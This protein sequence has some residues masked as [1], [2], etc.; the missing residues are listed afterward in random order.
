MMNH[1]LPLSLSLPL[2]G[3]N[4]RNLANLFWPSRDSHKKIWKHFFYKF[5]TKKKLTTR[6]STTIP[7]K[8]RVCDMTFD[9]HCFSFQS[10]SLFFSLS[11]TSPTFS[12]KIF[13]FIFRL[14]R[15]SVSSTNIHRDTKQSSVNVE[16]D[17]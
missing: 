3:P 9:G 2:F 1:I 5:C 17:F 10:L 13:L 15:T 16:E 11:S 7:M 4:E 6:F 8:K 14:W 12:K